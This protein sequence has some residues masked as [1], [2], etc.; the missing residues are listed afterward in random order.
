LDGVIDERVDRFRGHANVDRLMYAASA[1]GDFSLV[2]HLVNTSRALAP[3]RRLVH[4]ARVAA[5]L[6]LESALVNGPVKNLFG[7]HRPAWEQA[8]PLGLRRP[9]T[10]SF[11]SGHASSAMT[12]AGVLSQH[13]PL[14][15]LYYA[16]G[17]VVAGSRVYVKIHHPS[18][19][20]AGALLGAA[21][22]CVARRAWP[23]PE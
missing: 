6:G 19:V 7:R 21:L 11:P 2:W 5:I 14:W 10:S 12:A 17:A 20:V 13:D 15:P 1:L 4:A 22:A 16:I 23:F 18:D 3:D 9:L 8:R